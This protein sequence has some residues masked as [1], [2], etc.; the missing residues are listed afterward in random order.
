MNGNFLVFLT[1][2]PCQL[3]STSLTVEGSTRSTPKRGKVNSHTDLVNV[4]CKRIWSQVSF[5]IPQ[6][7][8]LFAKAHPLLCS[9]SR[10]RILHQAASQAK[11]PTL[12]GTQEFQITLEGKASI[13]SPTI[14]LYKRLT[15]NL[16]SLAPHTPLYLPNNSGFSIAI[17]PKN[18]PLP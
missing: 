17:S 7:M 15:V 8:H 1:K 13:P 2:K 11:I 5:S 18:F 12:G 6:R 16:P 10:V 14:V 4:Q 9:L 3:R